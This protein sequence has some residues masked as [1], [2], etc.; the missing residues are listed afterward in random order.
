MAKRDDL[1]V[2]IFTAQVLN[3]AD[4][5]GFSK[6]D[7]AE[8][9]AEIQ[10]LAAMPT[11]ENRY[12]IAQVVGYTVDEVMRQQETFLSQLADVKDIALGDKAQFKVNPNTMRAY[13]QAKGATTLRSRVMDKYITLD[14]VEVS[15]RPYIDYME[16]ATGKVDFAKLITQATN[17]MEAKKLMYIDQ[18]LRAAAKEGAFTQG[19]YAAG[20]G[21]VKATFDPLLFNMQRLGQ[22]RILGDVAAVAGLSDIAGF[23]GNNVISDGAYDGLMKN[24]HIGNYLGSTVHKLYSP[25][26]AGSYDPVID[27]NW[28]YL[29]TGNES[30][31]KVVNEGEVQALDA[32]NIDDNSYEMVLRQ[33]FGAAFVVGDVSTIGAYENTTV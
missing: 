28:L 4:E 27:K 17:E 25:L 30:P 10:K 9:N 18:V 11:P 16:L 5:A 14:T 6:V 3:K 19:S 1:A 2:Q 26:K 31:L 15:A 13:I 29:V 8:A 23:A 7:I 24:G 33:N 21:I 22:V 20:A 32:T 12:Q